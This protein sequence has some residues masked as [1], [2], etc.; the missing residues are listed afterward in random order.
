MPSNESSGS[1]SFSEALVL[2]DQVGQASDH[3]KALQALQSEIEYHRRR[4]QNGTYTNKLAGLVSEAADTSLHK[5]ELAYD[6]EAETPN[7]L[8]REQVIQ[9]VIDDQKTLDW[10]EFGGRVAADAAN[11]AMVVFGRKWGC[12]AAAASFAMERLHPNDSLATQAIAG[13]IGFG[14]GYAVSRLSAYALNETPNKL[15]GTIASG[16]AF[17]VARKLDESHGSGNRPNPVEIFQLPMPETQVVPWRDLKP[18]P[19]RSNS[20]WAQFGLLKE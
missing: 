19:L 12:V 5:L 16:V 6:K 20:E 15:L 18:Q 1:P 9:A 2:T 10:Q 13:A 14:S 17:P 8:S 7:A 4:D 11:W 3:V